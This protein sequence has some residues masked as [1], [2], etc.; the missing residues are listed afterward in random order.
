MLTGLAFLFIGALFY[1]ICRPPETTYFLYRF[2]ILPGLYHGCP[3]AFMLLGNWLPDFFHVFAFSLISAGIFSRGKKAN[4]FIVLFWLLVN[5]A[6][7]LGQ[8]YNA[9]LLQQIPD[10]FSNIPFLEAVDGYF[11]MGTFD[12]Y[13]IVA[14]IAGACAA[15]FF[16]LM[17]TDELQGQ[18]HDA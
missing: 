2:H 16:L 3:K 7:E 15:Y 8:K 13:D 1:L 9:Y 17:T 12:P 11:R 6:F 10:W 18:P 4:F 14:F 5:C